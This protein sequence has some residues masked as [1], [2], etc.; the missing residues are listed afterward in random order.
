MSAMNRLYECAAP[1]ALYRQ[2]GQPLESGDGVV[3]EHERLER[4]QVYERVL[5]DA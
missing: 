2:L 1:T 5:A 4:P 3:V